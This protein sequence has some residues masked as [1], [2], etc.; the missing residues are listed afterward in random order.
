MNL[1]YYQLVIQIE[2]WIIQFIQHRVAKFFINNKQFTQF[3]IYMIMLTLGKLKI[4]T[5]RRW[6]STML[7]G[8]GSQT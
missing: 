2:A 4:S 6:P 8:G 7:F 1:A 5:E 3:L